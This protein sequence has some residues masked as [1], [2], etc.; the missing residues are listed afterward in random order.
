MIWISRQP[1]MQSAIR[2]GSVRNAQT[3]SRGA[4][5]VKPSSIFMPQVPVPRPSTLL[6]RDDLDGI[7]DPAALDHRRIVEQH[8]AVAHRHIVVALGRALAAA[9]RIW[10]GGEQEVPQKSARAGM[11]ALGGIA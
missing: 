2:A 4:R 11:A 10:S 3:R 1:G 6:A 5:T 7:D 8:G 9:L